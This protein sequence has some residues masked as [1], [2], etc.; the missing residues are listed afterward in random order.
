MRSTAKA[1]IGIVLLTAAAAWAGDIDPA[2][3]SADA[4]WVAHLDVSGML[5]SGLGK[6]LLEKLQDERIQARIAEFSQAFGFD[7]R[8]DLDSVSLWGT[9]YRPDDGV[10]VFKGVF[11]HDRLLALLDKNEGH[12]TSQHGEFTVHRWTQRPEGPNDEGERYGTFYREGVV[13]VTRAKATLENA[14]DQLAKAGGTLVG[15]DA[16]A[17]LPKRAEGTFF[18]AAGSDLSG[19]AAVHPRAQWTRLVS[20]AHMV[21]GQTDGTV[22][23]DIELTAGDEPNATRLRNVVSGMLAVAQLRIAAAEQDDKPAPFWAP[24]VNGAKVGG[25]GSTVRLGLSISQDE[26]VPILQKARQAKAF[27]PVASHLRPR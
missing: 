17:L 18:F 16:P 21:F 22:F 23:L 9:G 27:R 6:A 12:E 13:L 20:S 26:L 4:K 7:P 25:E 15:Q 5:E 14:L 2:L 19:V 24:L 3:V 11:D 8:T 1:T 10:A